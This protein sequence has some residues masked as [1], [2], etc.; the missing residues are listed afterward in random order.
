MAP[1]IKAGGVFEGARG[2]GRRERGGGMGA[3]GGGPGAGGGGARGAAL[4]GAARRVVAR[5]VLGR[6]APG[7]P[8]AAWAAAAA[9]PLRPRGP[10]GPSASGRGGAAAGAGAGA[11]GGRGE[12]HARYQ[13]I[14][15]RCYAL[16]A[17][18]STFERDPERWLQ[19]LAR[20]LSPRAPPGGGGGVDGWGPGSRVSA[21][22]SL[23]EAQLQLVRCLRRE[24]EGLARR[25]RAAAEKGSEEP[26]EDG[27]GAPAAFLGRGSGGGAG[28][29]GAAA[30]ARRRGAGPGALPEGRSCAT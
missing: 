11:R 6:R 23:E 2:T 16:A 27:L 10:P 13:R 22:R 18:R 3:A 21:L 24:K 1:A 14:L 25:L 29:G 4:R 5:A 8:A 26:V 7:G 12:L 9:G 19:E 20:E 30:P 17:F 15:A 28:G